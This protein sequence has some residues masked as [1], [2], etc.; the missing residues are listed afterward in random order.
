MKQILIL[1]AAL[2][3]VHGAIAQPFAWNS[4][5]NVMG[6]VIPDNNAN[7]LASTI[8]VSGLVANIQNVTMSLDIT[9]GYNGDLYAYLAGPNGGFSV[10]LNRVGVSSTSAYGYSDAGLN[11]TLDDSTAG[12]D[13]HTYQN[14]VN[15]AGGQLTG[16]WNSDGENID[17]SSSPAS[18]TGSG[19]ATLAT[20]AGLNANGTWTLFL[21]DM[22]AGNQS[23][24]V[25]WSLDITTVPE[26]SSTAVAALA[27]GILAATK[28]GQRKNAWVQRR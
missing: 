10:L 15:P 23:T 6:G 13:I 12:A 4:T 5:N 9:G 2:M 24:I 20:F 8:G 26:P 7:G 18:F 3:M 22:A 19:S 11:I 25:S 16:T 1:A 27:L 21:A 14:T 17:P 28:A